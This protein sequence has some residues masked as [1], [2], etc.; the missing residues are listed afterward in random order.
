[1]RPGLVEVLYISTQD[2]MQLL[3]L[4][5]EQVI[6]TLVTHAANKP[7]T[8]GIGPWC[9]I[10]RFEYLDAAGCGHARETG[11]KVAI[12]IANE[13]FRRL[14]IG[15]CLSQLLCGPGIGRRASDTYM[16]H[17][18]RVQFDDEEGEQRTE[19]EVGDW[20]KVAGPDLLSSPKAIVR[21]HFL[22]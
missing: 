22:D 20:E 15:G 11:S 1:M 2:T 12:T 3:L 7:F 18:A 10:W 19:E 17:S 6:E 21:C 16:D 9:V 5:D 13:I 14:S 4:Q 8:D